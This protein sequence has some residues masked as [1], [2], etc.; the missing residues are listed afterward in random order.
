M[1]TFLATD[2]RRLD[3][4]HATAIQTRVRERRAM[5]LAAILFLLIAALAAGIV[6]ALVFQ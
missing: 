3:H 4:E 1:E 6:L 2:R 5:M